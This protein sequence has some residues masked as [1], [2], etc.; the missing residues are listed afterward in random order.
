MKCCL[1]LVEAV[2]KLLSKL[3]LIPTKS[4]HRLVSHNKQCYRYNV[5]HSLTSLMQVYETGSCPFLVAACA[6]A[7]WLRCTCQTGYNLKF[8]T[9]VCQVWLLQFFF[10]CLNQN[11]ASTMGKCSIP[12]QIF[13]FIFQLFSIHCE[14]NLR[15][16]KIFGMQ[17]PCWSLFS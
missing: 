3:L 16:T 9:V 2:S 12:V 11:N 7:L 17:P 15:K 13:A 8:I 14:N 1:Q 6:H 10:Q 4:T 5:F